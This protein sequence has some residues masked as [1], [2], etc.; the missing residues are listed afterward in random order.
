MAGLNQK[1]TTCMERLA[2]CGYR[3]ADLPRIITEQV[4]IK[5][6]FFFFMFPQNVRKTLKK[7]DI[8]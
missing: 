5:D 3:T 8:S 2:H 7:L 4:Q 6:V 1:N